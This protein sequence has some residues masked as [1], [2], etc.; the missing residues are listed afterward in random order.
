MDDGARTVSDSLAML[1]I[2]GESGT[3]DIVATPHASGQFR[4]DPKIV[5]E[6]VNDVRRALAERPAQPKVG[7]AVPRIHTGCDFH[8][9]YDNIE[10]AVENPRKYTINGSA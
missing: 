10:D 6:K 8:L 7:K 5:A 4:F 3:T 9:Q 2:A 1:D